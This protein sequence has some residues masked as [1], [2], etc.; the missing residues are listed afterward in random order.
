MAKSTLIQASDSVHETRQDLKTAIRVG[1]YTFV[2]LT[3]T[4]NLVLRGSFVAAG[5]ILA[6]TPAMPALMT[7]GAVAATVSGIN[8]LQTG[9]RDISRM[10]DIHKLT[11]GDVSKI[12]PGKPQKFPAINSALNLGKNAAIAATGIALLTMS[13]SALAVTVCAA[14]AAT[15]GG[16]GTVKNTFKLGRMGIKTAFK[17]DEGNKIPARKTKKTAPKAG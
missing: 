5:V 11:K 7:L 12:K 10:G 13:G 4:F 2:G 17:S 16:V 3:S 14:T 8:L 6:M 1:G 15:F 9:Y